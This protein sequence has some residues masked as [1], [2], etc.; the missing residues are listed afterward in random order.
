[1]NWTQSRRKYLL[2]MTAEKYQHFSVVMVKRHTL[3]IPKV[4]YPLNSNQP[5]A[6]AIPLFGSF[7]YPC[8]SIYESVSSVFDPE[9]GDRHNPHFFATLNFQFW[10]FIKLNLTI[11]IHCPYIYTARKKPSLA[12]LLQVCKIVE[13][14]SQANLNGVGKKFKALINSE[15]V[16]ILHAC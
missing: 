13:S 10:V 6:K 15:L 16:K 14:M 5:H 7:K 2:T 9:K 1:M 8:Y 3:L 12:Y 4:F 11:H